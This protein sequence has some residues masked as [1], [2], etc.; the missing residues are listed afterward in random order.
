MAVALTYPGV[1]IEEVPSGV[2]SITGAATSVAAFIGRTQRGP[3]NEPVLIHSFADFE[4][5]FGGLWLDSTISYSV[6][7]FFLNGGGQAVILRLFQP[8]KDSTGKEIAAT[9][10]GTISGL[11][12]EAKN[13]GKWGNQIS[14]RI[15]HNDLSQ[16]VAD[17]LGLKLEDL[18]NLSVSYTSSTGTAEERFAHVT[19]KDSPQ[20]IDRTLQ[21]SK[22]VRVPSSD[23]KPVLPDASKRPDASAAVRLDG[24][25]DSLPLEVT[26]Y[27][28]DGA[29]SGIY[30]LDK[31]EQF[32]LMVIPPDSRDGNTSTD[33]YAAALAYCVKR[34]AV[35]LIDPPTEWANRTPALADLKLSGPAA[36]N[37]AVYFPRVLCADPLRRGQIDTFPPSGMI[38][39]VLARTDAQRGVWK[40]PAGLDAALLGVQGLASRLSD[41]ENGQLNPQGINCLRSFPGSGPVVWGARTLRGSDLIADE[42]KYL[43]V[44]RLALHIEESLYRGTQW[45]VFEPNDEALWAQIRLNV[46]SFMQNL[47][48]QGAFAGQAASEAYFVKCDKE[49]TPKADVDL[50]I[51]NIVVG[52]APLKPAEFVVVKL[53]Q[54][55][56]QATS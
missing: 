23:G 17:R 2:R 14:V 50:G 42:Y 46:G 38:A 47:F 1:Y 44:R 16:E 8:G 32:S 41:G 55:A 15:D 13:P 53:Q 54:I 24:G 35:L 36:R 6:R 12:L 29:K 10:K 52:F 30:A 33:V 4:R 21:A 26:T 39:G 25:S 19:L 51:V 27:L 9:A 56:G 20:N 31:Q 11:S 43:S 3:V 40:A 34:R 22:F 37:A 18:F 28:G 48:R 49:T 5:W 7:D 45:V